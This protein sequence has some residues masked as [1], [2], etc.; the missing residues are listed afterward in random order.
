MT[1]LQ[2]P[3]IGISSCLLGREVRY[4]AGHK[5]DRYLT[6]ILGRHVRFVPVCPEIEVGMGVPRE[7]VQLEGV[8]ESPRM[9]GTQTGIDWTVRM[10]RYAKRRV[11]QKDIADLCGFILKS[12]SP[13]CGM[14]RVKLYAGSG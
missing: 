3:K 7:A 13:S 6:D 12:R 11:R 2:T 9:I 4:D 1:N 8:P 14:K 5:H 10:T